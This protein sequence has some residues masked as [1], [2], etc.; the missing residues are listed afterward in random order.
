MKI[1]PELMNECLNTIAA[2]YA[3]KAKKENIQSTEQEI[4]EAVLASWGKIQQETM[5]LYTET[6]KKLS[7]AA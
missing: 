2:H 4:N 1:I 5:R 7:E 6:Y 3:R